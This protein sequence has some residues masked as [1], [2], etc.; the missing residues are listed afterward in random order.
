MDAHMRGGMGST[1]GDEI[2]RVNVFP[3]CSQASVGKEAY[4]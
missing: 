1:I 2:V 3:A 4:V